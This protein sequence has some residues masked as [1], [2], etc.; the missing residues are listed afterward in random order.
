MNSKDFLARVREA[1]A[2]GRQHEVH[3]REFTG[4]PP[5]WSAQRDDLIHRFK[6]EA[7]A[8]GGTVVV[9]D[10]WPSAAEQV[11]ACLEKHHVKT[12]IC[13]NHPTL[14][15]LGLSALLSERQVRSFD[16][17][18]LA[19]L[20]DAERRVTMFSADIGITSA[21]LAIAETGSLL[22][23]SEPTRER[24]SSLLPKVHLAVIG[25]H[26]IVADLFDAFDQIP[27][28]QNGDLP[29]N[30][31]LITGPSKTGDL[32]LKLTTG[33]HGPNDWITIVVRQSS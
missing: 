8:A 4:A 25:R 28:L 33:V 12:A 29:S 20:S 5:R 21:T 24:V 13:W 6:R 10:T 31:V 11:V 19:R 7:E 14:D 16:H 1:A 18:Q 2:A 9:A 15:T 23:A 17:A 3:V 32:E 26:Q 27:N 30:I 22:M